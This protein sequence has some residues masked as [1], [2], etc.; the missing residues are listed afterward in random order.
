[1]DERT[2]IRLLRAKALPPDRP[3]WGCLTE[4]ELAAYADQRISP[5]ERERLESHLS[6]CDTC[7]EQIVFVARLPESAPGQAVAPDLLSRAQRFVSS[8]QRRWLTPVL[9]WGSVA[10][11]AC[12]VLAIGLHWRQPIAPSR[13]DVPR[14]TGPEIP[15]APSPQPA[16]ALPPASVTPA[17]PVLPPATMRKSPTTITPI[18]LVSP[19]EN[20]TLPARGLDF[21]WRAVPGALY[22]EVHVV[23]EDGTVVWQARASA[24]S[25]R[26]SGDHPLRTGARYFVWVR[27]YLASGGTIRSAAVSFRVGES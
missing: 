24:T 11:A 17:P 20:A 22:Y 26:L 15:E 25:T 5:E 9:G 3:G 16:V 19:Q 13:P 7:L 4:T 10:A 6:D 12:L 23:T 1:M 21:T 27:A 18:V 14:A 2:L 8:R